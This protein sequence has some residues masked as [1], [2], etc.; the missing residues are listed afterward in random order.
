MV[1]VPE[2]FEGMSN[3]EQQKTLMLVRPVLLV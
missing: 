1:L 3:I 2:T